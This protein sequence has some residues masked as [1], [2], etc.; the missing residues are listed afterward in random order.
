MLIL[1]NWF[2]VTQNDSELISHFVLN[3]VSFNISLH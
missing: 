3:L 2:E 1:P